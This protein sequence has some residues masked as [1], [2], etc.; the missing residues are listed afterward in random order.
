MKYNL[1]NKDGEV[2]NQSDS[3]AG[4]RRHIHP[5]NIDHVGVG[6]TYPMLMI[7]FKDKRYLRVGYGSMS[8]RDQSLKRWRNLSGVKQVKE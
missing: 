7:I 2:I 1:F 3:L 6:Q 4:I 5:G 8:D